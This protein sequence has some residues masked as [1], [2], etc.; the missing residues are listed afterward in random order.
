MAREPEWT[1]DEFR[2][3]LENPQSSSEELRN[4]FL[5]RSIGAIDCVRSGIHDFHSE[6]DSGILSAEM[7]RV[8]NSSRRAWTCPICHASL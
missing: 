7:R 2:V 5:N 4:Q 1:S 6:G 8:L 3:I